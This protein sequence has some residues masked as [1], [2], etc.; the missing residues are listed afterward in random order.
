MRALARDDLVF[1]DRRRW[2]MVS[3]GV[4]M[5]VKS[6]EAIH[7]ASGIAFREAVVAT[8]G[9]RIELRHRVLTGV[10]PDG[11]TFESE[12]I[13]LTQVDADDHL[14]ASI[15]FDADA[16]DAAAV[17]AQRRLV[18]DAA[19]APD[20]RQDWQL[21]VSAPG[22]LEEAR[23]R[24]AAR[25]VGPAT[26]PLAAIATG[27]AA[28]AVVDRWQLLD[29]GR[30]IDWEALRASCAPG[31]VFE[32]RQGFARLSGDRELM[33]ASLRERAAGA[34]R[35]ERRLLGTAGE[36]VAILGMLWSGGPPAGRFEIE[37]LAVTEVDES[38]LLTASI[39]FA[40]DDAR[41]RSARRGRA[42]RRSIR[43]PAALRRCTAGCSMPP[44]LAT[45]LAIAP[46]SPTRS[47]SRITATAGAS[48]GSMPTRSRSRSCG[49]SGPTRASTAAGLARDRPACR[50]VHRSALT[51][52]LPTA[53]RST[54]TSSPSPP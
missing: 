50:R 24:R 54:T 48:R 18:A 35:V 12:F 33:I 44:T 11:G 14:V 10:G 53:A 25:R 4:E 9:D 41:A 34:T 8:V 19:D 22:Q 3:G 7:G 20:E 32:D 6:A 2:S 29:A 13:V 26:A 16:G 1:E 45:R 47:W 23:A 38:G 28:T 27:N 21:D 42:G 46:C 15:N 5:W 51:V 31:L 52:T 40:P 39:L 49:S 36:R 17:E 37:Y 30:D 43:R